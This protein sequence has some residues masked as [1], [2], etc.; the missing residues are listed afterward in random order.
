MTESI[1]EKILVV[2]KDGEL[3]CRIEKILTGEGYKVHCFESSSAGIA[4]LE[5]SEKDSY[6]LAV[7]SFKMPKMEGDEI[8]RKIK[9]ISPDTHR[10]LVTDSLS[11]DIIIKAIN[12]AEIHSC[13]LLPFKDEDLISQAT[14]GC[15]EFQILE[16][17]KNL[18][19][20][21]Q[22]Q[23]KQMFKI[24]QNL[25]VKEEKNIKKIEKRSKKIQFLKSKLDK[26][27]DISKPFSLKEFIEEKHISPSSENFGNE[28]LIL[29]DQ[30]K[31]ILEKATDNSVKLD[32]LSYKE[33]KNKTVSKHEYKEEVD[34]IL[35]TS[36]ILLKE[37]N[38][39]GA[40][41][42]ELI[43][44]EESAENIELIITEDKM[45]AIIKLKTPNPEQIN[46]EQIKEYMEENGVKKGIKD[47]EV[48][49]SWLS[50]AGSENDAFVVANGDKPKQPKNAEIKYHFA[51]DFRHAGKV[52]EDGRIDFKD[53]G[54]I[55]FVEKDT[56]LSTKIF[57]EEGVPGV[58]VLGEIVPVDEPVE[59]S[60]G[61]GT[62]VRESEDGTKIYADIEGQP[63]LDSLGN[64]SVFSELMIDGDVSFETG[65][66]EFEGNI[67]VTGIVREG[68][69]I[70]GASLTAEQVEGAEVNLSGDLNVSSGIVDANLINVKGTVQA[71]YV[72]NSNIYG[73]EDL[74]VQKE[75]I[76]SKVQLSG[77]CINEGGK[78]LASEINAKGGITVGSIGTEVSTPSRLKVGTDERIN[79]LVAKLDMQIKKNIDTVT[80]LEQAIS[81]REKENHE[82]HKKISEH[83]YVQDRA[84]LKL[85][86][87]EKEKFDLEVSKDVDSLQKLYKFEEELMEKAKEA[88]DEINQGFEH[89]NIVANE[90]SH[91][92]EKIKKL[93]ESNDNYA[94]K[95]KKL[96]EF[97]AKKESVPEVK[98]SGTIMSQTRIDGPN[99]FVVIKEPTSRCKIVQV[100]QKDENS[101][102]P[103]FHEMIITDL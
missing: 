74:I 70:K 49:K 53:R 16:K 76:D 19:K 91:T 28:F 57:P 88:E 75:I 50:V 71:K 60:F 10:V 52:D 92:K 82:L 42:L 33:I 103:G 23:N 21:T 101:K 3:R 7:V 41:F 1:K 59:H 58:D 77:A 93:K 62:G 56:C 9:E 55:P 35:E 18:K 25:K 68:F 45:K 51:I 13:L 32:P 89:Q 8:L 67:V 64:I 87:L 72:N 38:F 17:K 96:L 6:A 83:A 97:T 65:N 43:Q 80:E 99:G 48:I 22:R 69:S 29:R 46:L 100:M 95:K 4:Q 85:K 37:T 15:R 12:T 84:Q 78:I 54:D 44:E 98:A 66:I 11:I 73:F 27:S 5:S 39:L 30:I 79:F 36:F 61:A 86:N 47:D 63:H 90:M 102:A 20:V 24:A 94:E 34:T 14:Q 40:D 81:V 26:V 2:E 31:D